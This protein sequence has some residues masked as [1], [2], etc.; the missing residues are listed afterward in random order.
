MILPP[1]VDITTVTRAALV[2]AYVAMGMDRSLAEAIARL[3]FDPDPRDP[4][5]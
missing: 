5:V 4:P 1:G 3:V 2:E